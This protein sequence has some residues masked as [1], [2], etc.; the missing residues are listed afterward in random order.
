MTEMAILQEVDK[1]VR[2]NG[3]VIA[4]KRTWELETAADFDEAKTA[5]SVVRA[6]QRLA[7]KSQRRAD[8]GPF[9]R[10]TCWHCT[11]PP[12][13]GSCPFD[14]IVKQENGAVSVDNTLCKPDLCGTGTNPRPC[15]YACQRGGYPKVGLAYAGDTT[16]VMNKCTMC[17]GRAGS[18]ADITAVGGNPLLG[19]QTRATAAEIAAS[20]GRKH[21]PACVSSCPAKAMMWD[22]K[23]NILAY[24]E[25]AGY[26]RDQWVGNGSLI[27]ASRS[28]QFAPPKADPFIEDHIAP[29]AAS[30]LSGTGK[31]LLP[32]LVVGG[33]AALSSRRTKIESEPTGTE[34][35]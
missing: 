15:E 18:D 11:E 14:A 16:P 5:G 19:L 20:S 1:C 30:M 2:C 4:C 34:E 29:M 9:V 6:R 10:F 24:L 23:E 12:C 32:T 3:C 7:I 25:D 28:K 31:M 21:E 26:T 33:L 13:A 17:S 8:M 35:V 22:T 27:W